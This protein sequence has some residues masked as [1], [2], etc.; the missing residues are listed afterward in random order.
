[1]NTGY[2]IF[3]NI[4]YERLQPHMENIVGIYQCGFRR[5]KCT[6]DQ[7]QP[8]RDILENFSVYGISMFH[9]FIDFKAAYDTIR[10]N[11]LLEALK[12]FKIPRKLIRLVKLTLEHARY[13]VKIHNNLSK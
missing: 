11:K 7:I 10:R 13:R 12:E 3:S 2:T 5:D 9:L 1:M 4:L 8:M 6:F